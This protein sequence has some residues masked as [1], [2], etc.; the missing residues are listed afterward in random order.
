MRRKKIILIG[1]LILSALAFAET[2]TAYILVPHNLNPEDVKVSGIISGGD[3][4]TQDNTGVTVTD[5][6]PSDYTA[7][8]DTT[9]YLK[10]AV[11]GEDADDVKLTSGDEV[12]F[13][14][15]YESGEE[16]GLT[17]YTII[18]S[19]DIEDYHDEIQA[20]VSA[21]TEYMNGLEIME[22]GNITGYDNYETFPGRELTSDPTIY[23]GFVVGD[24]KMDET[25]EPSNIVDIYYAKGDPGDNPIN[26]VDGGASLNPGT[27][28]DNEFQL[29]SL[30]VES[31]VLNDDGTYTYTYLKTVGEETIPTET[32]EEAD[33]VLL[34]SNHTSATDETPL[35]SDFSEFSPSESPIEGVFYSE[36]ESYV[37]SDG[38]SYPYGYYDNFV[39][40][41]SVRFQGDK[42]PML[43]ENG[44]IV[45]DKN[46]KMVMVSPSVIIN[47]EDVLDG[48]GKQFYWSF[49]NTS[50][51]TLEYLGGQILFN[52]KGDSIIV[53]PED[54]QDVPEPIAQKIYVMDDGGKFMEGDATITSKYEGTV[55]YRTSNIKM[56]VMTGSSTTEKNYEIESIEE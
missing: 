21:E 44:E 49:N 5:T 24:Q 27:G 54:G 26:V 8:G 28:Q 39:F 51:V 37:A 20:G 9:K 32:R 29:W 46:G 3:T 34:Y 25:G 16:A 4:F 43:D 14:L 7:Y 11:G 22:F 36:G 48:G 38:I 31:K 35:Y 17:R 18:A 47:G 50:D 19:P 1:S 53:V 40:D 33:R 55:K 23:S 56:K 12:K 45:Y 13:M 52:F 10:L 42:V 41:V 2:R 30:R 15:G 6:D